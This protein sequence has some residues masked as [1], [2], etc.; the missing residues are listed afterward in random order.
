LS[1]RFSQVKKNNIRSKIYYKYIIFQ[2]LF[3]DIKMSLDQYI[4]GQLTDRLKLIKSGS[5]ETQ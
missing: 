3:L 4:I 2:N 5:E 1:L